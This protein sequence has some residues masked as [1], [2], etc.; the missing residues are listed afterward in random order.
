MKK[1]HGRTWFVMLFTLLLTA[2][3]C[4]L[5]AMYVLHGREWASF[6]ANRHLYNNSGRIATGSITDRSGLLLYD[7]ETGAYAENG[8]IR[9][10]TLHA[11]G[12]EYGNILTGAKLLFSSQMGGY[13]LINGVSSSGNTVSL[14]I[15]AALCQTAYEALDG[16][17]GA[18]GVYNYKTGEVVCMV[19][20]PSFDP[21]DSE[22]VLE[23]VNA[24]ESRYQGVYLNHFFSATFTPGS[25]FKVVTSAAAIEQLDALEDFQYT[26][27]GSMT[28]DG[29]R[30]T[31][32]YAHGTLDLAGAL[33]DSCNGAFAELAL[34]LGG[35]VLY[36]YAQSAGLLEGVEMDGIT[37][38]AGRF[39]ISPDHSAELGWS[40]VGQSTNL[41]NPCAEM[42]LMGCIAGEGHASEPTLFRSVSG[43][44]GL[45]MGGS[46]SAGT[47]RIGWRAETCQ[48]LKTFMRNNVLNHYGQEQFGDL[49]VC[50]KSGT[51]EVGSGLEP[52]AW[53]T[54]FIDDEDNPYAFVVLVENGGSGSAEAGAVA[55]EVLVELCIR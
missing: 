41:V 1:L 5:L 39:E 38:A 22:E 34:E 10:A 33:E 28:V 13:D 25:I 37:S 3:M 19:S 30:I 42:V 7:G 35:D 9:T 49:A 43:P 47:A 36:G 53:F 4:V 55:A 51:A 40:G 15:D 54:G 48:I 16:R 23:A 24:G 2:G 29:N 50:A 12:D 32:P 20:S 14:T 6:S 11:V 52:H 45:P 44:F 21:Y 17:S 46:S 8:G 27:T 26:C 31:C 18:V